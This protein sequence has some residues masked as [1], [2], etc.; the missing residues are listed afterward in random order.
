MQLRKKHQDLEGPKAVQHN[1]FYDWLRNILL[2]GLE[3][4]VNAAEEEDDLLTT[5]LEE[6][7]LA[8]RMSTNSVNILNIFLIF[9]LFVL[10]FATTKTK[11]TLVL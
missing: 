4:A 5:V 1:L 10:V 9:F 8:L 7:P 11:K 3:G 2:L 6:Q